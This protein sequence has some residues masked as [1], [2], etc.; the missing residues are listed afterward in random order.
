MCDVVRE[1]LRELGNHQSAQAVRGSVRLDRDL[2]LGSLERVELLVRLEREFGTR[3]PEAAMAEANTVD[4]IVAALTKS[5]GAPSSAPAPATDSQNDAVTRDRAATP[6]RIQRPHRNTQFISRRSRARRR[7]H[8]ARRC[9]ATARRSTPD[10]PNVILLE[11]DREA[12]RLTDGNLYEGARKVA[13]SLA[14][15]GIAHGDAV[16]LMLPTCQEFFYT[17]AGILL[18]GAV[19]VPI[20]PPVRADR[21]AEYAERQSAIMRNAN[22]R[23][24]V[25]FREA[26]RVAKL[27]RPHVQSLRGIAT[28]TEVLN[29]VT[30]LR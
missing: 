27:L 8:L 5:L 29:R 12:H 25:T 11:D 10:R 18:A 1:L 13:Q 15:R 24:L 4:E 23:L 16:A 9:F 2:G 6:A 20:Y 3:L 26:E 7:R 19:P 22:V 14:R 17:F 28:A 21:I 30:R